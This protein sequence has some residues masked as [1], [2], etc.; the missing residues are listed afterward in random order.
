MAVYFLI[1]FFPIFQIEFRH[2]AKLSH[3]VSD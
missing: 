3:G 2:F 1:Q